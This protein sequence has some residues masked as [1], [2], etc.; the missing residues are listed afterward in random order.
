MTAR[1]DPR[2]GTDLGPYHIEAVLGRGGMGVV[3]LAEQVRLGPKQ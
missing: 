2:L 1:P 3:Y